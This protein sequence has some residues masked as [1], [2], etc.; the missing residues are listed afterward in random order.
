MQSKVS[1]IFQVF[2]RQHFDAKVVFLALGKQI[3]SKKAIELL[4]KMEFLELY[5]NLLGKIHFDKEGLNF[6]IFSS[7]K[8]LEK[9]L[10]KIHHFKL[11]EKNFQEYEKKTKLTFNSYHQYVDKQKKKLYNESF[12]LVVGSTLKSW[13]ELY[14]AAHHSSKGLKPLAISSAINQIINEELE[15]IQLDL[16]ASLDSKALKEIFDALRTIIM[17]ENLLIHLGFNPIFVDSIHG[18][19]KQ[20]K[21][22]LKPWYSN[23]LAL[24]S[25]TH[26]VAEKENASKKYLDWINE[27]KVQ[28]KSL[29]ALAEKQSHQL[30]DKILI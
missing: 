26:F 10:R 13:D 1:P 25:L 30:F 2:E 12:D 3:K 29:S 11:A 6:D 18:E 5:C 23:Q 9:N 22:S 14:S 15:F 24:Q 21:D 17:L 20:L 4:G 16:K 19:I 28:K 27:L 7:F 8:K